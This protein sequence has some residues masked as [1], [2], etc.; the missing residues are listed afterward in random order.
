MHIQK[1][2]MQVINRSAFRNLGSERL[3]FILKKICIYLM[4]TNA[5]SIIIIKYCELL[6]QFK[7]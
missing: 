2:D 6:L 4:L 5:A 1:E 7:N 3:L